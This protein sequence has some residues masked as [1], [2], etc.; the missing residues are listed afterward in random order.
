[1]Q[2]RNPTILGLACAALALAVRPASGQVV[3]AGGGLQRDVQRFSGDPDLNRLDGATRGWTVFGGVTLGSHIVARAESSRGGDID[4]E[5]MF[6]VDVDGRST[7]IRSGLT[8]RTRSIAAL[9][10]YSQPISSRVRL[11]FLGGA[12]F[13]HVERGFTTN[14]PGLILVPVPNQTVVTQ[15]ASPVNSTTL[16]DDFTAF[17]AGV[18]AIVLVL[19]HIGIVA[20][21]RAQPLDLEVDLSGWSVR[22]FLGAAWSF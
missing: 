19:R 22:P 16:E 2:L 7:T 8:H 13:T 21:I 4:D 11:V 17:I 1:M 3:L 5:Q 6:T 18:D 20:G 12:S 10:G 9:G 15:A 14:A